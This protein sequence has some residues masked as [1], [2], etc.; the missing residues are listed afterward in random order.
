MGSGTV[1]STV[2]FGEEIAY[3]PA[4]S[5]K[6]LCKVLTETGSGWLSRNCW[7]VRPGF[8][9]LASLKLSARSSRES[10]LPAFFRRPPS[11]TATR[12][13]TPRIR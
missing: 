12:L 2:P 3:G 11:R 10:L 8:V 5:F 6:P 13:F 4:R 9:F 1:E 7:R